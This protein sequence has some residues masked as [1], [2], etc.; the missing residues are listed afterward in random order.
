VTVA[1][2]V[3]FSVPG[4]PAPAG[5]KRAVTAGGKT[6]GRVLLVD[7]SRR[8]KPW[9]L[10]VAAA[11][12]QAMG[13]QPP[14]EGPLALAVEFAFTRPKAHQGARGLTA[15]GRRSPYPATRPDAT[16]L[17]RA[18]EDALTGIVWRDD[19]QVVWQFALKRWRERPGCAVKVGRPPDAN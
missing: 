13:D 10:D 8:S 7:A 15:V 18:V 19:A 5:S 1:F 9:K 12:L 3:E 4:V 17:L 16:K 11:A 2:L 14:L 6:G